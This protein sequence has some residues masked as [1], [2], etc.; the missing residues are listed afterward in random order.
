MRALGRWH[1][2]LAVWMLFVAGPAM[3][4]QVSLRL[5]TDTLEVGQSASLTIYMVG[6]RTKH[7]PRLTPPKGLEFTFAGSSQEFR[8]GTNF[9]RTLVVGFRYRVTALEEGAHPIGPFRFE[10]TDGSVLG[11]EVVVLSVIPRV[12]AEALDPIEVE[13]GFGSEEAW[14]GQVVVYSYD[15]SA[16]VPTMG[17]QWQ[18]PEFDGFRAPQHGQAVSQDFV[19][20][21]TDGQITKVYGRQPLIATSTG[22]KDFGPTLVQVRV[23]KGRPNFF[24]VRS[25]TAEVRAT[26]PTALRVRTLPEPP[27][28]FSGLVGDFVFRSSLDRQEAA[29]GESVNWTVEMVGDGAVEGFKPPDFVGEDRVSVYDNG[30]TVNARI[31]R[32]GRYISSAN[33]K[34]V[35]VPAEEGEVSLPPLQVVTFSPRLGDYEIHEIAVPSLV[36]TRGREGGGAE[37]ESFGGVL[38]S[39]ED[40]DV[41]EVAF[42]E[43]YR[44]GLAKTPPFAVTAVVLT[45]LSAVPAGTVWM[46]LGMARMRDWRA[47]RLEARR[48]PPQPL[49]HLQ[50]LPVEPE[51]RLTALDSAL[52]LGLAM[53]P[54]VTP[55]QLDREAVLH[56]LPDDL[57]VR[58]QDLSDAMDRAR[59][60]GLP[61]DRDFEAEIREI[62][63]ALEGLS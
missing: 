10:M 4:A 26:D 23:P 21:D 36:V 11:S 22:Q 16:R 27:A 13:A 59:F 45:A 47:A 46:L 52:R 9:Q 20:E 25:Y 49:D 2:V 53:R 50:D 35:L 19:I 8:Q 44:W 34:R 55:A 6:G 1:A 17:V 38:P 15:L 33:F 12:A 40:V 32:D 62:L 61:S 48:R 28:A 43:N 37:L 56:G 30:G 51:R 14:E 42:R 18:L 29:V 41:A 3:A 5:D 63:Q 60:A 39:A 58:V 54:G 57:S 31:E 7:A 24:G